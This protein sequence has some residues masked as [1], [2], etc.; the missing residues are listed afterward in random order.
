MSSKINVVSI[1]KQRFSG[2][3]W[4]FFGFFNDESETIFWESQLKRSKL[5]EWKFGH[6]NLRR[7][8]LGSYLEL[9]N[10][11]SEPFKRAFFRLLQFLE[12]RSWNH[13][14]EKWG[15]AFKTI[16]IKVW[17]WEAFWK[18]VLKLTWAQ[19]V[20]VVSVWI[21]HFSVFC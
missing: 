18:M 1:W 8:C 5:F 2:F 7:K 20:N 3:F 15:N 17:L 21:G 13:F 14:L 11:C 9:K 19:K 10:E 16:E 12:W 6:R 4:G